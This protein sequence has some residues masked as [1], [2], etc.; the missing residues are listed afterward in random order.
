MDLTL[1]ITCCDKDYGQWQ[2]F[3]LTSSFPCHVN[4]YDMQSL[5]DDLKFAVEL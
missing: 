1:Q 4:H 5:S 2:R 3:W